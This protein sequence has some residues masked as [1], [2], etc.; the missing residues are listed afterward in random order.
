MDCPLKQ[1]H[2]YDV[3]CISYCPWYD[4]EAKCCAIL[5][6]S[7]SLQAIYDSLSCGLKIRI[8]TES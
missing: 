8:V 1:N 5:S 4:I 2:E 6:I 7:N 3:R